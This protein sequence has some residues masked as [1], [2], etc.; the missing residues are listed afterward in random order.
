MRRA[1]NVDLVGSDLIRYSLSLEG[2]HSTIAGL[3]TL[4]HLSENLAMAT[5]FEP[6]SK[7][8]MAQLH[9]EAV[10]ALKD[11]PTPWGQPGYQDGKLA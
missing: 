11:I 10:V 6:L 5:N 2:V 1:R 8:R 3:D 4:A 7:P 9:E